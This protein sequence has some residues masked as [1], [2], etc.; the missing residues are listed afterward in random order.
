MSKNTIK[1]LGLI[2]ASQLKASRRHFMDYF[3]ELLF[4]LNECRLSCFILLLFSVAA[5]VVHITVTKMKKDRE[6]ENADDLKNKKVDDKQTD[7]KNSKK[8]KR[9]KYKNH[10]V[11]VNLSKIIFI[12]GCLLSVIVGVYTMRSS[13]FD[14]L[15]GGHLARGIFC[16]GLIFAL[17]WAL[18]IYI[19][20]KKDRFVTPIRIVFVGTFVAAAFYFLPIAH[21]YIVHNTGTEGHWVE[22]ILTSLQFSFRLFILDGELLWIY[23]LKDDENIRY[24]ILA[25]PAV[26]EFYTWIGSLLYFSAPI[27]TFSFVLTFFNNLLSKLRYFFGGLFPTHVFNELN[28]KAIALATDIRKQKKFYFETD[29][30]GRKRLKIK[31]WNV[32]VFA[33]ISDKVCEEKMELVEDARM[34]GAILFNK[35]FDSIKYRG[36]ISLRKLNFY[37]ISEDEGKKL[38][39]AELVMKNYDYPKVELRIFSSDIRSQL[40]MESFTP[41]SMRAIRIDDIQ[42]LIYHNLYTHGKMLFDR[43][44][45]VNGKKDKVISA[46]IVGLGQYGKEM[47]KALTWFCQLKGYLLKITAFDSDE[48][49]E[50]RFKFL[51]PELMHENYNGP[52]KEPDDPKERKLWNEE[53]YYEIKIIDGINVSTPEFRKHIE[54]ITDASYIFVCLGT[55]EINLKTATEIRTICENVDYGSDAHKPDIETVVYDSRLATALRTTWETV[56]GG[57]EKGVFNSKDQFYN[58]LVT[59]DLNSFYSVETLIDSKF[60][61]DGFDIHYGYALQSIKDELAEI[62]KEEKKN[63]RAAKKSRKLLMKKT[64]RDADRTFWRHEY[65]YRSSVARAIHRHLR[66]Q[67]KC[68]PEIENWEQLSFEEKVEIANPEHIRWNAYIRSEGYSKGDRNLLGKRHNNLVPTSHLKESDLEKD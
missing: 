21:D 41:E 52:R 30:N 31:P 39:H 57:K 63:P 27:L 46:V 10:R 68:Y 55:D 38:R 64:Q 53:P 18:I 26:R 58:I 22:S 65:N 40:L 62:D 9:A 56:A 61:D 5:I 17:L 43:A 16:S 50:E 44:R 29:E 13:L 32:I 8:N 23:D 12:I 51:C 37:L 59:G 28:E 6:T 20:P 15:I 47:L 1:L 60:I 54:N 33:E 14:S 7:Q 11:P 49:A 34:L 4:V 45:T 24:G 3:R 2:S 36:A 19:F 35:D 67:M 48:L 25:D 42:M 66:I